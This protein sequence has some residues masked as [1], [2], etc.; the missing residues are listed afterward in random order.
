MPAIDQF[1]NEVTQDRSYRWGQFISQL[2]HPMMNGIAAFFVIGLL[3]Q[4]G[5]DFAHMLRWIAIAII[6]MLTPSMV[7]FRSR[8][9]RGDFSDDDV[10]LRSERHKLYI[11]S[12]VSIIAGSVILA[13]LHIPPAFLR[14]MAASVGIVVTCG[15][16]NLVW[17]ISVHAASVGMLATLL[18]LFGGGLGAS[19]WLVAGAVGWARMRTGNHTIWQVLAGWGVAIAGVILAFRIGT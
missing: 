16:V 18:T 12:L 5:V 4:T 6:V 10:S 7:Y 13:A 11:V 15:L 14:L 8:L 19:F 3:G 9:R 2:F 17:K 1:G